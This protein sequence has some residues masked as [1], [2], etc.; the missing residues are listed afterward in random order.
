[1]VKLSKS[2]VTHSCFFF[3]K[4]VEYIQLLLV[5]FV[6]LSSSKDSQS[7]VQVYS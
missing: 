6:S 5:D 3:K 4:L 1:M 7:D 2:I